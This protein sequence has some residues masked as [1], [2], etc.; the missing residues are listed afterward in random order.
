MIKALT[1]RFEA[2]PLASTLLRRLFFAYYRPVVK[3][4]LALANIQACDH[5][6]FVGVG[7]MPVSAALVVNQSGATLTGIDMDFHAVARASHFAKRFGLH[8]TRFMHAVGESMNVKDHNVIILAKQLIHKQAVI[9]HLVA[10]AK[11]GTRIIIR[12]ARK[13]RLNIKRLAGVSH[14]GR[15]VS[16]SVLCVA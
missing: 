13:E 11:A 2:I 4:E 12:T 9:D 3:K 5:V 8:R 16:T 1:K 14:R 7:S 15:G 6:L 10:S